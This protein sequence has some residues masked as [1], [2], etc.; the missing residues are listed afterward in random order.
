M[1]PKKKFFFKQVSNLSHSELCNICSAA[2]EESG[3]P[4]RQ[5][6]SQTD[7]RWTTEKELMFIVQLLSAGHGPG[8]FS[9]SLI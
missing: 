6:G 9:Y 5:P 4:N 3:G 1:Q 7:F 8:S 2:G